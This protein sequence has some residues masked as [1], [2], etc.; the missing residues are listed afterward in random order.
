MSESSGLAALEKAGHR[1]YTD[2]IDRLLLGWKWPHT[3][4]RKNVRPNDG[5][6]VALRE[7]RFTAEVLNIEKL[8]VPATMVTP[9]GQARAGVMATT[10]ANT[11]ARRLAF[12][13]QFLGA[14]RWAL[15]Q[16][17]EKNGR[18]ERI[19]TSDP[20]LPKQVRYQAA[21]R[22]DPTL[23]PPGHEGRRLETVHRP[24]ARGRYSG[25]DQG[26]QGT[27]GRFLGAPA[28]A[29]Q[30]LPAGL[31]DAKSR[32]PTSRYS[33]GCSRDCLA[34]CRAGCN[35]LCCASLTGAPVGRWGVA[36]W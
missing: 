13:G 5:D 32:C 15:P 16:V 35:S 27:S 30:Q 18:S 33:R 3:G 23:Q 12:F 10:A 14:V 22:S 2:E 29:L 34:G 11:T 8:E 4:K 9:V 17:V 20:L 28:W 6:G 19:R 1:F 25:H 26:L 36:K 24:R 21:L 31:R 7:Y